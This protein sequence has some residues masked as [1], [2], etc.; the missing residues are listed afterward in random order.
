MTS[1]GQ[2]EQGRSRRT[3]RSPRNPDAIAFARDQRVRANEFAQGVWQIVRNRGCRA[4]KFRREY[5]IPPYTADFCCV[6]LKLVLEVDGE[7]HQTEDGRECDRRRDHYLAERG[8]AVLRIPGYQVLQDT[9][10]VRRLIET[11][12]DRRIEQ[13]NPLTPD[14]SP[15]TSLGERGERVRW[16]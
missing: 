14:P 8:Y 9:T 11:T 12:I 15:P 5:S 1:K 16:F 13:L 3:G 7:D 2:R 4:Q 6:A 10:G